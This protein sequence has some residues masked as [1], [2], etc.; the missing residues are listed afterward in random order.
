MEEQKQCSSCRSFKPSS[1]FFKNQKELKSCS[2]CREYQ[3]SNREIIKSKQNQ[4]HIK[5]KSKEYYENH[6]QKFK[7]S[8]KIFRENNPTYYKDYMKA[9]LVAC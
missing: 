2:Q 5:Q 4:E 1:M 8:G 3:I 7:E 6:K 9:K